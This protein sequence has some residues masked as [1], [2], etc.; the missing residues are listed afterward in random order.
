MAKAGANIIGVNCNF[1]P[2]CCLDTL[3]QMKD[4]LDAA[5]IKV[6][7][8]A[9]PLGY[10]TPDVAGYGWVTLPEFPYGNKYSYLV[11]IIGKL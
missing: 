8:M 1:D 2:F 5:D 7:L 10:K 11:K 6:H 9:Q 4:A 3:R